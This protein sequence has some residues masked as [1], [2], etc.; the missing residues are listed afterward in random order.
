MYMPK[1]ILLT[2]LFTALSCARCESSPGTETPPPGDTTP[3]NYYL[4]SSAGSDSNSGLSPD[5]PWK[6]LDR[7]ARGSFNPGDSILLRAGDAWTESAVWTSKFSGTEE[8]PVVVS[9]YGTGSRPSLSAY[10]GSVVLTVNNSDYLVFE[11]IEVGPGA[12]YGVVFGITD[13]KPHGNIT[14]RNVKVRDMPLAGIFFNDQEYLN[15]DITVSHCTGDHVEMLFAVSSG[16][17]VRIADCEATECV[18]GGFSI[19]SVRDGVL[20]RCK[21]FRC[22]TG[23]YPNG[24][25]G[26]FLGINDGFVIRSTEV[27][28]QKR[29]GD[30]PDGEAIDFERDNKNVTVTDCYLHDNDGCAVMFFDNMKGLMNEGCVIENTRFANNSLNVL[31]P[32]GFEIHFTELACNNDGAIRNNTFDLNPGVRFLTTVDPSVTVSGNKAADGTP[33]ELASVSGA[34]T[35][36]DAGFEAPALGSGYDYRPAGTAWTFR[37]NAGITTSVESAFTPPAAPEG[38]Q[39]AFV[40]GAASLSQC[41]YLAAGSYK[42]AFSAAYRD[43]SGAGQGVDLYVNG[44]KTGETLYPASG[45]SFSDCESA[46]FTV[47]AGVCLIELRGSFPGDKTAFLDS[48]RIIQ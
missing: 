12:G 8:L 19:I 21:V 48:F 13:K 36:E 5:S 3:K 43:S 33:L 7:V 17:R 22:G 2:L 42:V 23:N 44:V 27:A 24:A 18:Y 38:A 16:E 29:Q 45:T 26:I 14:V 39:T 9:S 41:V 40:Q 11:N 10:S 6:S 35:F 20:E 37:G 1:T 4:S 28:Y 31:S 30:N 15:H 25:C 46:S 34:A 32:R 47:E